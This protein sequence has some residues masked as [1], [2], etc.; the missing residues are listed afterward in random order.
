MLLEKGPNPCSVLAAIVTT[1]GS[2]G[3]SPL[4]M[5]DQHILTF[6]LA[7]LPCF[8][9]STVSPDSICDSVAPLNFTLVIFKV[10][11]VTGPLASRGDG[12]DQVMSSDPDVAAAVA[13]TFTG[14]PDGTREQ[15]IEESNS[16]IYQSK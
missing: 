16:K 3:V 13:L 2:C 1:T 6:R 12:G 11:P 14:G 9:N 8:V 7:Q 10:N 15:T 5:K 4:T